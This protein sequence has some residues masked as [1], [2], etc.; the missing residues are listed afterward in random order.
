MI[1][2]NFLLYKS[3]IYKKEN[4]NIEDIISH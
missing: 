3:D 2:M 4:L 1:D